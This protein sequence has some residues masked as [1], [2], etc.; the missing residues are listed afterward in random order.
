VRGFF[1]AGKFETLSLV[2]FLSQQLADK[3]A[4]IP[5]KAFGIGAYLSSAADAGVLGNCAQTYRSSEIR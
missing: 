2:S 3:T 1:G 5:D 4:R